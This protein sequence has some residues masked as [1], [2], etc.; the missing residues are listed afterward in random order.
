MV[1]GNKTI[2]SISYLKS[3]QNESF[4]IEQIM[5]EE[6][7]ESESYKGQ[8]Y[9]TKPITPMNN[10]DSFSLFKFFKFEFW[11]AVILECNCSAKVK[12]IVLCSVQKSMF[13]N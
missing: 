3:K 11:E 4:S 2:V 7:N 6:I 5:N 12:W 10:E 13:Q 8:G 9:W 1:T